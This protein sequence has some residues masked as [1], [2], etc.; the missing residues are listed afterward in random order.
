[1]LLRHPTPSV[2][3][4]RREPSLPQGPRLFYRFS[5]ERVGANCSKDKGVDFDF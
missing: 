1:M 3:G 5:R 4:A 2:P